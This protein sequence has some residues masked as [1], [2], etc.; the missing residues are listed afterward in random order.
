MTHSQ[1]AERIVHLP[2]NYEHGN[3]STATLIRDSGL[4]EK[5]EELQPETVEEIL[6]DEPELTESWLKRWGDQRI[7]GG[8]VMDCEG[9]SYRLKNFA[10]G[11]SVLITDK[12]HAIAEFIVRYV[13][14]IQDV[15]VKYEPQGR[16]A[17][18]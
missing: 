6:R 12:F 16:R 4:L 8:W 18:R 14:R 15:V 10:S 13:R 1:I 9:K 5:P 2:E 17:L 7:A 3:R 11:R